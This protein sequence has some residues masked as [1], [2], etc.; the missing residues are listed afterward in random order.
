MKND[1]FSVSVQVREWLILELHKMIRV[2]YVVACPMDFN[3]FCD[4]GKRL[5]VLKMLLF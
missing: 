1:H 3:L 2:V 5:G 4:L